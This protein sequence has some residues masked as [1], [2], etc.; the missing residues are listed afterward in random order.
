ATF[1]GNIL[2]FPYDI[3]HITISSG[4]FSIGVWELLNTVPWHEIVWVFIGVLG[5]GFVNFMISFSLAF[6]VALKSRNVRSP[7]VLEFLKAIANHFNSNPKDFLIP[8]ENGDAKVE[9]E[10]EVLQKE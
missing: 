6:Y 4:Y 5:V 9:A 3:R 8:S 7:D 2:G 1:I 10:K